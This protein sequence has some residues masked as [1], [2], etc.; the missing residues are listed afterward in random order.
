MFLTL[1]HFWNLLRGPVTLWIPPW[2]LLAPC[3]LGTAL[4]AG[5]VAS[6]FRCFITRL[7]SSWARCQV[8]LSLSQQLPHVIVTSLPCPTLKRFSQSSMHLNGSTDPPNPSTFSSC[9]RRDPSMLI[10]KLQYQEWSN[11]CYL[12]TSRTG[13]PD[14][15]EVEI[16]FFFSCCYWVSP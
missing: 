15:C 3:S 4:S 1:F 14:W 6:W 5:L 16:L 10:R 9:S 7:I 8:S 12:E 2:Q 11:Q 13:T